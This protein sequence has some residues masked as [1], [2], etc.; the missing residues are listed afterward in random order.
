MTVSPP[1]DQELDLRKVTVHVN[2][3]EIQH[4]AG[5]ELGGATVMAPDDI[6]YETRISDVAGTFVGW[7]AD[8]PSEDTGGSG[9]ISVLMGSASAKYLT[10]VAQRREEVD[11]VY[12]SNGSGLGFKTQTMKI[13][14]FSLSPVSIEPAGVRM[15]MFT[16]W[17]YKELSE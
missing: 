10:E 1:L 16:G 11:V 13:A 14:K 6:G 7:R 8:V 2:G 5:R 9:V 15:F 4:R 17:G 12:A 3:V